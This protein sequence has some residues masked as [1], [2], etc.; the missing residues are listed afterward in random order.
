LILDILN[1]DDRRAR[2]AP[3]VEDFLEKTD[4]RVK[5]PEVKR[6]RGAR[7]QVTSIIALELHETKL[8]AINLAEELVFLSPLS[9]AKFASWP[10]GTGASTHSPV[11]QAFREDAR[12]RVYEQAS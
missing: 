5:Y 4:F 10:Y 2:M 3:L 7:V 8:Q 12:D 1:E 6:R 9:L 11:D